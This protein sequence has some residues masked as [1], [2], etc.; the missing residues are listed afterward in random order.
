VKSENKCFIQ[1]LTALNILADFFCDTSDAFYVLLRDE[2]R[3]PLDERT[4]LFL[5]DLI[6]RGRYYTREIQKRLK[7]FSKRKAA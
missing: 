7:V 3:P 6:S 2:E 5:L 4:K 1:N